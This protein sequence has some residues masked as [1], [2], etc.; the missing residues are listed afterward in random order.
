[1]SIQITGTV[2]KIAKRDIYRLVIK[3]TTSNAIADFTDH[4]ATK[5]KKGSTVSIAGTLT[6]QGRDT[7]VL[8][9]CSIAETVAEG[10]VENK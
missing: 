2:E 8:A 6:S 10:R 9:D 1:M 7:L 4:P 5:L 3:T